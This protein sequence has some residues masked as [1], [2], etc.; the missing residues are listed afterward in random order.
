MQRKELRRL[1]QRY[2][3]VCKLTYSVKLEIKASFGRVMSKTASRDW[4]VGL[5]T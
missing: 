1:Q 4:L 3:M 2:C 5:V